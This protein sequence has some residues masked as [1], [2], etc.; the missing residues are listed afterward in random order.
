[1]YAD[2]HLNKAISKGEK[3]S[4][5]K[6]K[7]NRC[8]SGAGRLEEWGGVQAFCKMDILGTQESWEDYLR[9]CT[10]SAWDLKAAA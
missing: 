4:S 7:V 8:L 2:L 5:Y 9:Q 1:M 3:P 6:Q 10:G